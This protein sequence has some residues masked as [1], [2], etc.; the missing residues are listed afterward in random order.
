MD[1]VLPLDVASE[2]AADALAILAS[3]VQLK[4]RTMD[5]CE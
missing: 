3:K 2:T 5:A 4:E 1:G